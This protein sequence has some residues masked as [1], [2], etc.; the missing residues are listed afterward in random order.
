MLANK[1]LCHTKGTSLKRCSSKVVGSVKSR[2]TRSLPVAHRVLEQLVFHVFHFE[3]CCI[4]CIALHILLR[5]INVTLKCPTWQHRT[6]LYCGTHS[7]CRRR[8]VPIRPSST[9]CDMI[10]VACQILERILLRV[11]PAAVESVSNGVPTMRRSYPYGI[12]CGH[13]FHGAAAAQSVHLSCNSRAVLARN[14]VYGSQNGTASKWAP[15]GPVGS[16]SHL[17]HSSHHDLLI[18]SLACLLDARVG[19][20]ASCIWYAHA[21]SVYAHQQL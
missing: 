18:A 10:L 6:L 9:Y 14:W 2:K 11:R 17:L 19:E 21:A 8:V 15:A 4:L 7:Q 20:V 1:T 3:C 5:R 13:S 12:T 16:C